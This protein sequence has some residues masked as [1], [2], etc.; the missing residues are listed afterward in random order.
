MMYNKQ[1]LAYLHK[2]AAK[3]LWPEGT[4]QVFSSEVGIKDSGTWLQLCCHIEDNIIRE[5]RYRVIGGGYLIATVEWANV[6][7]TG[8]SLSTVK[9]LD[10]KLIVE[11]LALPP[12]R[13]YCAQ[14][15][16]DAVMKIVYS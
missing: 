4:A 15:L 2:A 12:Q 14:M 1:L 5:V 11:A 9:A 16:V 7:L 8:K 6:F 13:F 10:A 3:P